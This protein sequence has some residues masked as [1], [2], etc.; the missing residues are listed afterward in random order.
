MIYSEEG[1]LFLACKNDLLSHI[2]LTQVAQAKANVQE[3]G[4]ISKVNTVG[5][6]TASM[7]SH[8]FQ[9]SAQRY[10]RKVSKPS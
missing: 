1:T 5:L 9:N 2:I 7:T 8:N 10:Q 6:I 3:R 4:G